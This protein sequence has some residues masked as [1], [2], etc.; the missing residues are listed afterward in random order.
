MESQRAHI[1]LP[2]ALIQ[3]IDALVGPRGRSAFL[4]ETVQAEIQ[5]RQLLQL[6]HNKQPVWKDENH[7]ELSEGT[8]SWIRSLRQEGRRRIFAEKPEGT[9][10]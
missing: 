6:L 1:V 3:E 5:R 4:V 7:P 8:S 9:D 10:V 2:E